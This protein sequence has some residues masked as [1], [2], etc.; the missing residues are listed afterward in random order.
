MASHFNTYAVIEGSKIKYGAR[1]HH[2]PAMQFNSR[3]ERVEFMRGHLRELKA[4]AQTPA[5]RSP[6]EN[7]EA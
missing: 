7:D 6:S 2:Y 1:C 5:S 4:E 3:G